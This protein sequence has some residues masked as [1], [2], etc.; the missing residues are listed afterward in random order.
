M[1]TV[2]LM[3]IIAVG[4]ILV[5][6]IGFL[7]YISNG[8]KTEVR[9]LRELTSTEYHAL[10][11]E[12]KQDVQALREAN[13]AALSS[14]ADELK[15][16][17]QALKQALETMSTELSS[18]Q[19][20]SNRELG[21]AINSARED[22]LTQLAQYKEALVDA[23]EGLQLSQKQE[24]AEAGAAP[25]APTQND[26]SAVSTE[27]P[28][29]AA[30]SSLPQPKPPATESQDKPSAPVVT[31]AAAEAPVA[32]SETDEAPTGR[33]INWDDL[34]EPTRILWEK[35]I[36]ELVLPPVS[37]FARHEDVSPLELV[38]KVK[39]DPV[40]CAKVLAVANSAAQG[41]VQP[42]TSIDR[43]AVQ[44]GSNM[45]QIIISAYHMEAIFGRYAGYSKEHFTFIQRWSTG[46]AV[47]AYHLAVQVSAADETTLSTAALIARLGSL[48]LGLDEHRPEH[49]YRELAYETERNGFETERWEVST[50]L[51][52]EQI[53]LRWGLPEPLPS[54]LR[55]QE[56]PLYSELSAS[57]DDRNL[58]VLCLA[59]VLASAY[60]SRGGDELLAVIDEQPYAVLKR[61]VY[62]L[63]LMQA[64][65]DTWDNSA[66]QREFLSIV[67]TAR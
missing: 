3:A 23:I 39:H 30:T 41:Q 13:A 62:A 55:L 19:K 20:D 18:A 7:V 51:L 17:I 27:T 10:L 24:A 47:L 14:R 65:S 44:L 40:L 2:E 31:T 25:T 45:L 34:P 43:A 38:A 26:Q 36:E 4:I 50:P 9:E 28:P 60:V 53:A 33:I 42:V 49:K 16:E 54:L 37:F 48:L 29:A 35:R 46:A 22:V 12:L 8:L 1:L 32:P 15:G 6:L 61:N 56:Q 67:D 52:S 64:A 59:A 66:V 58:L 11:N 57:E 63:R 5:A 21:S